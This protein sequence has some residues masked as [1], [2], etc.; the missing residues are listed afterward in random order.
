MP[1]EE[2]PLGIMPS[3]GTVGGFDLESEPA[4]SFGEPEDDES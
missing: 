1:S 2:T 3:V 4:R